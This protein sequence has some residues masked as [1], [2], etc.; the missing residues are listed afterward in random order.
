M[1]ISDLDHIHERIIHSVRPPKCGTLAR[2]GTVPRPQKS[3]R[4]STYKVIMFII[5]F[6]RD[7]DVI[8]ALW[9]FGKS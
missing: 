2:C 1:W 4:R 5:D 9:A 3:L 7:P 6:Q 8:N